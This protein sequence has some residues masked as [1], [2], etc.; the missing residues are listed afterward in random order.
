MK[1]NVQ[2]ISSV[3]R[4]FRSVVLQW[5]KQS[6]MVIQ[7]FLSTLYFSLSLSLSFVNDIALPLFV[8]LIF[9][10]HRVTK[11]TY[12]KTFVLKALCLS[13][14]LSLSCLCLCHWHHETIDSVL[15]FLAMNNM[16]L[17][18]LESWKYRHYNDDQLLLWLKKKE[19][20]K[21]KAIE[22]SAACGSNKYA[23][24]TASWVTY[25]N[26]FMHGGLI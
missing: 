25:P 24:R 26:R 20:K 9:L 3:T 23:L 19:K 17:A 1:S 4:C 15:S 7:L 8:Y 21:E 12:M 10:Q 16:F 18:M 11:P 5:R 22:W 2:I 13:L 14:I 6:V